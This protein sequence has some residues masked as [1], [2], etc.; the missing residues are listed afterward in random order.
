LGQKPFPFSNHFLRGKAGF[1]KTAKK[2]LE[3]STIIDFS[4]K[5]TVFDI[6]GYSLIPL[7]GR[8]PGFHLINF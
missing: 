2:T 8:K 4:A 7:P 1:S 3:W 5:L 6:S